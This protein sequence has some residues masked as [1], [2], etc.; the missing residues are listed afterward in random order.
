MFVEAATIINGLLIIGLVL[1]IYLAIELIRIVIA[2]RK[3]INR[4]EVV[5]DISGWFNFFRKM[6]QNKK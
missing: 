4:V 1:L 2:A 6:K 5:S 3:L